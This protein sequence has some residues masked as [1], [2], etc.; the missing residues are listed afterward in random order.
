[1]SIED[2]IN[3]EIKYKDILFAIYKAGGYVFNSQI[4]QWG[5]DRNLP[6]ALK[7]AGLMESHKI[8]SSKEY[9]YLSDLSL[10][11]IKYSQDDEDHSKT[12]RNKLIVSSLKKVVH[13]KALYSSSI[14]FSYFTSK[15]KLTDISKKEELDMLDK[16]IFDKEIIKFWNNNRL[17]VA[18]EAISKTIGLRKNAKIYIHFK[19]ETI[20]YKEYEYINPGADKPKTREVN[21][22]KK[23]FNGHINIIDFG[24]DVMPSHF[25]KVYLEIL[26]LHGTNSTCNNTTFTIY[27]YSEK[28]AKGL[29]KNL[30]N[31]RRDRQWLKMFCKAN[32]SLNYTTI[33]MMF[34]QSVIE[35]EIAPVAHELIKTITNDLILPR[36]IAGN[37]LNKITLNKFAR[38]EKMRW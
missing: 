24:S 36:L 10:R 17:E 21:K 38:L 18:K 22:T 8:Q 7:K 4:V 14:L 28:R 30:D 25:I 9:M 29:K 32:P 5:N 35:I 33:K 1:M 37:K 15:D 11:F 26:N 13:H 34:E 3:C 27:S 19:Y 20:N 23:E 16:S 2:Y 6:S 31:L 12:P